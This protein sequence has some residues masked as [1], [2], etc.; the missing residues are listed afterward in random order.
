MLAHAVETILNQEFSKLWVSVPLI[1]TGKA[2][3]IAILASAKYVYAADAKCVPLLLPLLKTLIHD[4]IGTSENQNL[5]QPFSH[6][7]VLVTFCADV[8]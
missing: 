3:Q 8:M 7:M 1:N 4:Y 5:R 2:K 6:D